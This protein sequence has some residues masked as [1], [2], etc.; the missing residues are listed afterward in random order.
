MVFYNKN[1][2]ILYRK[3]KEKIFYFLQEEYLE[4]FYKRFT[5]M[6]KLHSR[7]RFTICYIQKKIQL[8]YNVEIPIGLQH[9]ENLKKSCR[10][11]IQSPQFI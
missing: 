1:I 10:K 2:S 7:N 5:W 9:E 3:E 11:K 4:A 8:T 6:V